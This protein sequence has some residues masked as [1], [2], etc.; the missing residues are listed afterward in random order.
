[1]SLP[2]TKDGELKYEVPMIRY[3]VFLRVNIDRAGYETL[4]TYIRRNIVRA[5]MMR[6]FQNVEKF[7]QDW[8]SAIAMFEHAGAIDSSYAKQEKEAAS[9]A[10]FTAGKQGTELVLRGVESVIQNVDFSALLGALG[11]GALGLGYYLSRR[12]KK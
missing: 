9:A 4:K 6:D 1:M 2:V 12:R 7:K 8:L 11:L 5:V 10:E 3:Y